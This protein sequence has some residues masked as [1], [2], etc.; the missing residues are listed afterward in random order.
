MLDALIKRRPYISGW[1]TFITW[2]PLLLFNLYTRT[3]L[4]SSSGPLVRSHSTVNYLLYIL[5]FLVYLNGIVFVLLSMS[6]K[7][8]SK[9]IYIGNV[10]EA[11][12]NDELWPS[13]TVL[14]FVK[15]FRSVLTNET[16]FWR[17][18]DFFDTRDAFI[19]RFYCPNSNGIFYLSVEIA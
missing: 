18:L 7:C 4:N 19:F 12:Q 5:C 13:Y 16:S 15:P 3:S 14:M 10:S 8:L 6:K 9:L 2:W 17:E 11:G 1:S